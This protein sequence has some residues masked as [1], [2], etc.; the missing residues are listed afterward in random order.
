MPDNITAT[1]KSETR[2]PIQENI[3][4]RT[5]NLIQKLESQPNDELR[6]LLNIKQHRQTDTHIG[7]I[8]KHQMEQN[9]L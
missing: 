1:I 4:T 9:D 7:I 3:N 8:N 6:N 2:R 5:K